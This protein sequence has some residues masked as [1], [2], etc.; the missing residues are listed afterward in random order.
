MPNATFPP[1]QAPGS[2]QLY[3]RLVTSLGNIVVR[4]EED[5]AP[6]Q[7]YGSDDREHTPMGRRHHCHDA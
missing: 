5:R 1:I 2:G 3:A 6:K 7:R 4:L